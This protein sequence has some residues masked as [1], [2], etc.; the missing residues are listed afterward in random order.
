ME[1][2]NILYTTSGFIYLQSKGFGVLPTEDRE[3]INTS[4]GAPVSI[5]TGGVL[6]RYDYVS[7]N[8]GTS[9]P[10]SVVGTDSY[11]YF[12]DDNLNKIC[13]YGGNEGLNYLSDREGLYS[14]MGNADLTVCNSLYSPKTKE[15]LFSLTD[16]SI[17]YNEYTKSFIGFSDTTF[18]M[19][20]IIMGI[21]TYL[22]IHFLQGIGIFQGLP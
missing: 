12:I 11:L 4:T 19:G 20:I 18:D 2:C 16:E 9:L 10:R 5:G 13:S 14:Y 17:I 3:V 7:T 22:K 8:A 21:L 15:I 6:K 1:H